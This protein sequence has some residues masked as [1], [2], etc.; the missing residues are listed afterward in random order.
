MAMQIQFFSLSGKFK[1]LRE[2][3]FE[4][5]ALALAAVKAHAEA[6]G[7]TNVQLVD[8]FGDGS[9][10]YTARTPGGRGGRNVAF[11]DYIDAQDERGPIYSPAKRRAVV[12]ASSTIRSREVPRAVAARRLRRMRKL[13]RLEVCPR[14]RNGTRAYIMRG[15]VV[16]WTVTA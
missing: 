7:F 11:G 12:Y 3:R 15:N 10:R 13:G 2:E 6:A 1:R 9:V 4:T 8:D 16:T 5:A 14:Y